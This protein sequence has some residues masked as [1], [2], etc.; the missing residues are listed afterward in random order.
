MSES[1][2]LSTALPRRV[3]AVRQQSGERLHLPELAP[4]F[5]VLA[6]LFEPSRNHAAILELKDDLR[7]AGASLVSGCGGP[8]ADLWDDGVLA[9]VPGL[10]SIEAA[11]EFYFDGTALGQGM[12]VTDFV[13]LCLDGDE[14]DWRSVRDTARQYLA[15]HVDWRLHAAADAGRLDEVRQAIADGWPLEEFDDSLA[16]TPLHHAANAGH[17]EV[18][19]AL[20]AAGVAVDRHCAARIGDT[21]LAM[22]AG[23]GSAAMAR[24][25]LD[26]G[27]DPTVPGWMGLSALDRVRRRDDDQAAA[28]R[29]VLGA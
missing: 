20:L 23:H 25:L 26:A 8:G 21:A 17:L 5:G 24:L 16:W 10:R 7:A 4:G 15:S 14:L 27:A 18:V 28:V 1:E 13:V 29:A 6:L 2:W 22:V 3:V 19:R 11:L 12:A 9:A